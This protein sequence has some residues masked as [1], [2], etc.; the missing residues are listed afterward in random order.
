MAHMKVNQASAPARAAR[1]PRN[2]DTVVSC[3]ALPSAGIVNL[4]DLPTKTRANREEHKR[5]GHAL[6]VAGQES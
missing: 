2:H 3:D 4:C 6:L 5:E 1:L